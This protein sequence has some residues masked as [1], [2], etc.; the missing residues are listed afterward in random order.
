MKFEFKSKDNIMNNMGLMKYHKFLNYKMLNGC[1]Q[2]SQHSD[3]PFTDA[4]SYAD[5]NAFWNWNELDD[6]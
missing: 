5:V 1:L 6:V 2:V 3:T 4:E